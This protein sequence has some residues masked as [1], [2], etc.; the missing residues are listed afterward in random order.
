MT[1]VL[2]IP[3]TSLP[4]RSDAQAGWADVVDELAQSCRARAATGALLDIPGAVGVLAGSAPV[5]WAHGDVDVETL[6]AH[7]SAAP[8][9]V[10]I[11]VRADD[12]AVTERLQ[13]AGWHCASLTSQLVH[14]GAA[15][16]AVP[17]AGYTLQ[18]LSRADLPA[19]RELLASAGGASDELI[20]ACYG[21]DF[22]V[23][24]APAW[25]FGAFDEGGCLVGTVGTRIQT[26]SAMVFGLTVEGG[27]QR[28]GL[29]LALVN[30][31]VRCGRNA[32]AT[33]AHA[34]GEPGTSGLA[35][36]AGFTRVGAWRRLER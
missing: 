11:N 20:A 1:A 10:E 8:S 17:P 6:L 22:F 4:T 3:L 28:G 26:R 27:H 16:S 9:V 2:E 36:A 35:L 33:F 12:H 23:R 31:A 24:A 30:A 13:R 32:G 5:V 29:A 19:F 15:L 21:D 25:L 34:S 14:T 7:V 18:G